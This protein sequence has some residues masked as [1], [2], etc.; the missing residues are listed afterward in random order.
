MISFFPTMLPTTM[1][2]FGTSSGTAVWNLSRVNLAQ[3]CLHFVASVLVRV[4]LSLGTV[5]CYYLYH[6]GDLRKHDSALEIVFVLMVG[7]TLGDRF[8]HFLLPERPFK[9]H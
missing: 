4:L 7:K 3:H 6:N 2:Y 5:Y 9:S 1:E 8:G